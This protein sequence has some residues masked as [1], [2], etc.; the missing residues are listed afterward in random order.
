MKEILIGVAVVMETK[1]RLKD[2]IYIYR[3]GEPHHGYQFCRNNSG[4][5]EYRAEFYR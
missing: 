1:S 5:R 2:T 3:I 4:G